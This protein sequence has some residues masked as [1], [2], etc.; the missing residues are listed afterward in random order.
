MFDCQGESSPRS[1]LLL[2]QSYRARLGR[3]DGAGRG[4]GAD[5][6]VL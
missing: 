5:E 1:L 3:R 6:A 2:A 4:A